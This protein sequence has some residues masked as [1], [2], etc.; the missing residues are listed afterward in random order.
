MSWHQQLGNESVSQSSQFVSVMSLIEMSIHFA[1]N[2]FS[3]EFHFFFLLCMNWS[4][5]ERKSWPW[6]SFPQND[7]RGIFFV[8]NFFMSLSC[9]AAWCVFLVSA[10]C[11]CTDQSRSKLS[12]CGFFGCWCFVFFLFCFVMFF[13]NSR[14]F[15]TQIPN[16]LHLQP[17]RIVNVLLASCG[18]S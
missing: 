7:P 13:P 15:K 2:D 18:Y 14:S 16:S 10:A 4:W 9:R 11:S 3:D 5:R 8:S 6:P 1:V 17:K 12:S